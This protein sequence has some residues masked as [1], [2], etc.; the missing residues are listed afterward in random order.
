MHNL[1][2][3]VLMCLPGRAHAAAVSGARFEQDQQGLVH[4]YYRLEN[5]GDRRFEI[6][7]RLSR[8]GGKTFGLI[9]ETLAGDV[10]LVSGQ[11]QKHAVWDVAKDCPWLYGEGYIFVVEGN[12]LVAGGQDARGMAL[13]AAGWFAMG[14]PEGLGGP[15]EHPRHKVFLDSY[16]L[17]K[18][19]V[20]VAQYRKF[21]RATGRSMRAQPAWSRDEHPVVNVDWNDAKAY[22]AY[23]GKRLPTEAEWEKAAR[24]GTDTKYSFGDEA[25]GLA[26]YAWYDFNSGNQTHPVGQK[27]PNQFG[28]YDMAGNVWEWVSDWY[29]R[30][31]YRSSPQSNPPG[32]SS[33]SGRVVRGGSMDYFA[34]NSRP[35]FR[36]WL[37]PVGWLVRGGGFDDVGFRCARSAR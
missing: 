22:C 5:T 32:P 15:Q 29:D 30:G 37:V 33:G 8:D 13:I 12:E 20:A 7:L 1:I 34:D 4:I 14:S 6:R 26:D 27:Q 24:G 21:C 9:P 18:Y 25:G 17:D 2:L 3:A 11:G 36:S 28:I 23:A 35:A 16:Y 31:Y 19:E 10:G